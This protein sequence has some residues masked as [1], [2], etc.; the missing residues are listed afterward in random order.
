MLRLMLTMTTGWIGR[1]LPVLLTESG[2][3]LRC[4]AGQPIVWR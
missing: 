2:A 4:E 1:R 3:D